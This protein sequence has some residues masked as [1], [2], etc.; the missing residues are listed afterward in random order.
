[1]TMK[2]LFLSLMPKDGEEIGFVLARSIAVSSY[3]TLEQS[4]VLLF[5]H[6]LGTPIDYAGVPFFRINNARARDAILERLLKK[7]YGSQYNIFWNS[8]VK[9]LRSIN[10]RRNAIVHWAVSVELYRND[11]SELMVK[12]H[13]LIAPNYWDRN[14]NSLA[15]TIDDM[16]DFIARCDFYSRLLSIFTLTIGGQI[17]WQPPW[18]DIFQQPVVY[19]PPDSHPLSLKQRALE[20]PPPPSAQ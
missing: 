13:A 11:Q 1:M 16:F 17:P 5:S 8:I 20:S 7:R 3:Q 18:R 6:L 10:E 12:Q 9:D 15:I 14:E 19:P 2:E 4:M